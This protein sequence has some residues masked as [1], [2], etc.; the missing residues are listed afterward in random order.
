M[1]WLVDTNVLSEL[2]RRDPNPGVSRW[3]RTQER[4]HISAITVEEIE[5]GLAWR[6][7][8]RLQAWWSD[9]LEDHCVV[10]DVDAAVARGAGQIRGRLQAAGLVRTQADML[11][12][13]TAAA[14]GATLVTRNA[15]DFAGC[16]IAV[17]D[18]FRS[19]PAD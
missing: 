7:K 12:A 13:A 2:V 14:R 1:S 18:P 10:H 16:G 6:P 11:I 3:V 9:F 17:Y 8:P 15:A 4:L 5:F 19:A